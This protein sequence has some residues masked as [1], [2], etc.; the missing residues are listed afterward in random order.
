MANAFLRGL[1][2]ALPRAATKT[3]ET[4][5]Q[6]AEQ[7]SLL[8]QL[9]SASLSGVSAVGNLLDVPG[10]MV[11]DTLALDNPFDQLLS[12][13][14]DR[15]R[16]TGR[17][18]LR[19]AGLAGK[20]DT[21]GNFAGGLGVEIATDPL[22]WFTGPFGA[23]GKGGK[24]LK[25]AGLGDDVMRAAAK[26]AGLKAGQVGKNL[27]Q[28]TMT[29]NRVMSKFDT[30][31]SMANKYKTAGGTAKMMDEPIGGLGA[32]GMPFRD[33]SK[34]FGAASAEVLDN[35]GVRSF[36]EKP[37]LAGARE[38]LSDKTVPLA[39][40]IAMGLDVAGDTLKW[41]KIPG[42]NF[43]PGGAFLRAFDA[44]IGGARNP[45]EA[46]IGKQRFR[47]REESISK[48]RALMAKWTHARQEAGLAD[49]KHGDMLR[50]AFESRQIDHLPEPMQKAATEMFQ[51]L[52]D[53][54]NEAAKW[55]VAPR[56][57]DEFNRHYFPRYL[58]EGVRKSGGQTA[59]QFGTMHAGRIGRKE[60]LRDI[61]GGTN[62]IKDLAKDSGLNQLIDGGADTKTIAAYIQQNYSAYIPPKYITKSQRMKLRKAGQSE[63]VGGAV[64]AGLEPRDTYKAL[65]KW[66]GK[67]MTAETR[68]SGIFGNDPFADLLHYMTGSFDKRTASETALRALAEPGILKAMPKAA[69][70]QKG[71]TTLGKLLKELKIDARTGSSK[72]E[73]MTG[74][75]YSFDADDTPAKALQRA[76]SQVVDPDT[77][78]YLK[79]LR[80]SFSGPNEDVIPLLDS[81]T[82]LF[83]AGVTSPWPGFQVRNLGSG[84]A[85]NWLAGLFSG[86]SVQDANA[87]ARGGVVKG[88]K[89]IPELQKMAADQG[90]LEGKST[91]WRTFSDGSLLGPIGS[92]LNLEMNITPRPGAR[93]TT[94]YE[95]RAT[96]SSPEGDLVGSFPT[97]QAA[98]EAAD[99][100]MSRQLKPSHKAYNGL[101]YG[102]RLTGGPTKREITEYG[103]SRPTMRAFFD[104]VILPYAP[105]TAVGQVITDLEPIF[106]EFPE[107]R[108]EM[109]TEIASLLD[110]MPAAN[111]NGGR[112][113]MVDESIRQLAEEIEELAAA[114][115]YESGLDALRAEMAPKP[116]T[117]EMATKLLRQSAYSQGVTGKY[118][119]M[120]VPQAVAARAG[121]KTRTI[122]GGS[123]RDI[124]SEIP[125]E[126]PVNLK[127]AGRKFIGREPGT[128][129]N[130]L[131]SQARG[132]AGAM[133]STFGPLA[134]GEDAGHYV[135]SLN[136]LA[137]YIKQLRQGVDPGEAARR[138]S[139]AQV[140]YANRNYTKF[141]QQIMGRLFPFYK[142]TKGQMKHQLG[143]LAQRPGGR[144]ANVIR[145]MNRSRGQDEMT[146]DYVAETASIPLGKTKA[147]DNRYVTGLGLAFE[148]PL[149]MFGSN[150]LMEGL[151]RTNPLIKGPTEF[152]VGE[153]FFQR[154]P[155]GGR[156]L[157]DID[158]TVGRILANVGNL[159]GLRKSDQAVK[160]PGGDVI[161]PLLANSPLSKVF[162]TARTV[163]DQRKG[164]L[165]RA[166]NLGTGFRISDISPAAQD[167]LLRERAQQL[168][169]KLGARGF[170]K[171]WMPDQVAAQ[172]SPAEKKQWAQL[173][174]LRKVLEARA[175]GRVAAK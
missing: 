40:K 134:A 47:G 131:K 95:L 128:T 144:T 97:E 156:D 145:A 132:V 103:I 22:T 12:P 113:I 154:G 1:K 86:K 18:L 92:D 105:D 31:V 67:G 14:T 109:A 171:T 52:D 68:K 150:P 32:F 99:E 126:V 34:V 167:A 108:A 53:M 79:S 45:V 2:R 151:S 9:G 133:E 49:D 6:P 19:K 138:V 5:D 155:E 23:I 46:Q 69:K 110:E 43:Q 172:M 20:K 160:I 127:R 125:G 50:E 54:P 71:V 73:E 8:R 173:V 129:L 66:L 29:P 100:I 157:S 59:Q 41:G 146:P 169:K 121:N 3:Q 10:S 42:T 16:N 165:G 162:T 55:G 135:E 28:I 4:D 85:N 106:R 107:A 116:F 140:N 91:K 142:F 115:E 39:A 158:P 143:E 76:L 15:N 37:S 94:W 148:D 96:G 62:R 111:A 21:W 159:T 78:T 149:S 153:S 38:V 118:E 98:K 65:A 112:E 170:E 93:G 72:I 26:H 114:G 56:R 25:A 124:I 84:Q 122:Q 11:R 51:W 90:L 77:A 36:L 137:P 101:N 17:D 48:A 102:N 87:L 30:A 60:F 81:F 164:V 58:T 27:S 168:E 57:L 119:G 61:I 74:G 136:R 141:E 35:P 63:T 139:S 64:G 83:K 24:A 70:D 152:A 174:A 7:Q 75:V 120:H 175:K 104:E 82:N 163:T 33:P 44:T 123:M 88:A 161:E 117:D 130:P 147:G 89:D 166:L 13:L 80:K